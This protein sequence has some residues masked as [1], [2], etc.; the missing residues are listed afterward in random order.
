M[1]NKS[2]SPG[3]KILIYTASDMEHDQH[4]ASVNCI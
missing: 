3:P 2:P 1:K 4:S